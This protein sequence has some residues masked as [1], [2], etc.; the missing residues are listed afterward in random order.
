MTLTC[1]PAVCTYFCVTLHFP[2][3]LRWTHKEVTLSKIGNLLFNT[4]QSMCS[5]G[6]EGEA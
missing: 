2:W 3:R 5:K 4:L 6:S 1:T